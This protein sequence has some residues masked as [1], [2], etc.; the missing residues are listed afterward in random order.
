MRNIL[1][2]AMSAAALGFIA[3]A[4]AEPLKVG[5]GAEPYPPFTEATASGE[6]VG[7]EIDL[8]EALCAEM[9][10]ECVPAPIAWDGIIPALTSG[11]ID[12]IL[13]S[14]SI[15]EERKQTVSFS[16]RYYYT[17]SDF[18]APK[19]SGIDIT[20]EGMKG[21]ILGVQSATT[22]AAYAEKTYTDGVEIKYYNT[23]DEVNS[24]LAAGRIDVMLADQIAMDAFVKSEAGKDMEVVGTAPADPA[25]GEGIGVALRKEDTDLLAKVNAG[26]KALLDSGKYDEIAGKYFEFDIYGPK[27]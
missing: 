20:P 13:G 2:I 3:S 18:V 11:Q 6:W 14:L 25:F 17:A 21:K 1:R 10:V 5:F 26:I 7:F 23:Q 12:M 15:T 19:G 24:D 16:D 4:S 27:S 9:Q 22:N 8:A